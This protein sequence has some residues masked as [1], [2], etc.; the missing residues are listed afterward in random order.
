MLKKLEPLWCGAGQSA[1]DALAILKAKGVAG[2]V[3]QTPVTRVKPF[4]KAHLYVTFGWAQ[5]LLSESR[6]PDHIRH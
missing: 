5:A 1:G 6:V 3:L 4:L 2:G